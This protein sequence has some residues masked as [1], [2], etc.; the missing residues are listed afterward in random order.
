M[1]RALADGLATRVY[2]H[3]RRFNCSGRYLNR[4]LTP[5]DLY[6]LIPSLHCS[7]GGYVNRKFIETYHSSSAILDQILVLA[8]GVRRV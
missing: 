8:G 4:E 2:L 1:G 6:R 3:A 7:T 5:E